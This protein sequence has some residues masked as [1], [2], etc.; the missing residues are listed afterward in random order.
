MAGPCNND[1]NIHFK[2][3]A[4]KNSAAVL[5]VAVELKLVPYNLEPHLPCGIRL[6]FFNFRVM[7]F[8]NLAALKAYYVVMV[9]V[10]RDVF[11]TGLPVPE[12]A[13][14]GKPALGKEPHC[15][16]YGRV[17][18]PGVLSPYPFKKFLEAYMGGCLK[19]RVGYVVALLGG[20]QPLAFKVV[21]QYIHPG[22]RLR[23]LHINKY[24]R[25]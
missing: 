23:L 16:V 11:I 25:G 4:K 10:F 24:I 19:E 2:F 8:G 6:E 7:E 12:L 14:H 17:T 15:P 1:N 18:G 20:F 22:G 21:V 13:F 3:Q 9:A 5:A